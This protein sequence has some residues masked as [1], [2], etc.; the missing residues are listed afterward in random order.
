MQALRFGEQL[1]Y[2]LE[3]DPVLKEQ[4]FMIPPML[5]QPIIENALEHGFKDIDYK[6]H[7]NIKMDLVENALEILIQDN[8]VGFDAHQETSPKEHVS[9]A[10]RI[11]KER[12]DLLNKKNS[13]PITFQTTS[14][15]Q[16]GTTVTFHLPLE[17]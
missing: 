11:T 5:V 17:V 14:V 12:I 13:K 6:G 4:E 7:L 16:Q 8:G 3:I 1:E 10:T 2:T 9:H 15:P